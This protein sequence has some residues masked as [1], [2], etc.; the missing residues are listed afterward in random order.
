MYPSQHFDIGIYWEANG[1]GTILFSPTFLTALSQLQ[2]SSA[3]ARQ[4]LTLSRMVNQ[5]VGDALS[6]ILLVELVLLR[7]QWSLDDWDSLY[8]VWRC[9]LGG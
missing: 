3:A 8:K 7:K 9:G 5:T 2:D 1:H 4:L 6:G